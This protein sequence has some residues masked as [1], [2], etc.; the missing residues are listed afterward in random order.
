MRIASLSKPIT[1][2]CILKMAED[3]LLNL[4][5]K[6]FGDGSILGVFDAYDGQHSVN[7]IT[8]ENLLNHTAGGWNNTKNDPMFSHLSDSHDS[9]IKRTLN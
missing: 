7:E 3:G 6:V 8:V 9:L 5:D 2:V 1:A 4:E